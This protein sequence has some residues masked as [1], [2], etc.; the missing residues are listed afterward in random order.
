M[1]A[2]FEMPDNGEIYIDQSAISGVP[3]HKRPT[4][5]VFQSYAIFPHLNVRRNIALG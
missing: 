4:N 5:M 2:G 1:L 3:P